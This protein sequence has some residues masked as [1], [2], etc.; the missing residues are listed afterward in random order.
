[1]ADQPLCSIV[2]R[3]YNE[4]EH[5]GRLL[6]GI[7][8][9][10]IDDLEIV[11][12]D[13]GSSDA[14]LAIAS[15]FPTKIIHIHPEDFTFGRSLNLGCSEATGKYLVFASAHV[16]PLYSDWIE[17]LIEP[18]NDDSIA[19]SYGKQRGAEMT[20]YSEHRQFERMYPDESVIPQRHPLCNN[21][22]AA[23]RRELWEQHPYNE[24]L[25]G[26]E[27]LEWATWAIEQGHLLAYTADAEVV[28]VHEESPLQVLQRYKR[29][30]IALAQIRPEES[31]SLFDFLRLFLS[32]VQRDFQ[33]AARDRKLAKVLGEVLW[34]RWM[35]FWGTYIGFRHAGPVSDEVIQAFYYPNDAK[36]SRLDRRKD[37]DPIDY[38]EAG[39]RHMNA[40][41]HD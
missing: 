22:N 2:I 24:G 14:T 10:S 35:Q 23:I 29:E 21:A 9:Q 15:R 5:I 7:M 6:A 13:S 19:L 1:M 8:E 33:Q 39:Q 4:E 17:T 26:L 12:V 38:A 18:F 31:F 32:N 34:F 28:H 30:A 41:R 11:V 27:D 16:Y 36:L 3:A 25:S 40:G 37:R 20:R